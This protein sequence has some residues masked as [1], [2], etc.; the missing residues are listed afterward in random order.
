MDIRDPEALR[1]WL[2]APG[3]GNGRKIG[4]IVNCSAYTAVD[5]AEDEEELARGINATGAGNIAMVANE[6]RR[7][8]YPHFHR[9]RVPRGRNAPIPGD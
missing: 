3:G 1:A 8:T 4:W 2:A 6:I 9:L 5:K 7:Q